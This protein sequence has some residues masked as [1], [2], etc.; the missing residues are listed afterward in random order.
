MSSFQ[1]AARF[2]LATKI[3]GL[4]KVE[5][6]QQRDIYELVKRQLTIGVEQGFRSSELT[7]AA[8]CASYLE[9]YGDAELAAEAN[10]SFAAI[11]SESENASLKKYVDR[12][13]G[14]ARRL[15]LLGNAMEITGKSLDGSDFDW[16]SYRGKVV[17]VDFWATWCGPCLAEAPNARKHYD[18]YHDYGFEVVGISLDS[19]KK[20]LEAYVKKENV[21]WANL[22]QE[23]TGWKHPIA[24]KY[25]IHAIPSVFLVDRDGKV[26]SLQARGA[27]LGKQLTKLIGP[28]T[29]V[30]RDFAANGEWEQAAQ[31]MQEWVAESPKNSNFNWGLAAAQLNAGDLEGYRRTCEMAW[32]KIRKTGMFAKG[33][34]AVLCTMSDDCGVELEL[35]QEL[36][37]E[38]LDQAE[39]NSTKFARIMT[40]YRCGKFQDCVEDTFEGG[41][42]LQEAYVQMIR[43]M[44]AKKLG[45]LDDAAKWYAEGNTVIEQKL[46]DYHGEKFGDWMSDHW[47]S[48]SMARTIQKEAKALLE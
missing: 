17:L 44:A 38:L 21:P 16:E 15:G 5:Q 43:A 11:L 29:M 26:V 3:R 27:E 9:R 42:P 46:S 30:A 2:A 31:K 14:S 39:N 12:F 37:K 23:V 1:I 20:S 22:F 10:R 4:A 36:S 19:S 33:K 28:K 47:I 35:L 45:Q 7:N 48:C 41:D 13:E 25:G 24:V 8:S 32:K 40:N 34:L 18:I 6:E